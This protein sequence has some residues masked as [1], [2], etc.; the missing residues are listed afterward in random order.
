MTGME[1]FYDALV[2]IPALHGL[3]QLQATIIL[4]ATY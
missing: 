3:G 1:K 2:E 4:C